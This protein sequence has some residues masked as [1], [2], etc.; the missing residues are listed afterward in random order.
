[1]LIF[2]LF[3]ICY[4]Y[5]VPWVLTE[6]Y[7]WNVNRCDVTPYVF[8]LALTLTSLHTDSALDIPLREYV[9]H[10]EIENFL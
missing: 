9:I 4:H 6:L 8:C 10:N 7:D 5:I 1:M 2:K 3:P